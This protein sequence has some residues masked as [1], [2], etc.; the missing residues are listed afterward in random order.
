MNYFYKLTI[1]LSYIIIFRKSLV[2]KQFFKKK[3]TKE[4][5]KEFGLGIQIE[6]L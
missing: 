2:N 3:K 1:I 6:S 4:R 5:K